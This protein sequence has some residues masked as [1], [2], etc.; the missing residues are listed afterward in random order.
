K[1]NRPAD[2]QRVADLYV[3][4]AGSDSKGFI[5][6][7]DALLAENKPDKALLS[8]QTA[9][10]LDKNNVSIIAKIGLTDVKLTNYDAAVTE[11]EQVRSQAAGANGLDVVCALV[12]AYGAKKLKDKLAVV[13]GALEGNK[14]LKA[15]QCAATAYFLNGNDDKAMVNY[16]AVVVADPKNLQAK[17]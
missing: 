16:Q 2:A 12:E 10:S 17:G 7:G 11:L 5:L 1:N 8:F 13:G 15:Q 9:K 4:A 6:Q 3:K 14:E